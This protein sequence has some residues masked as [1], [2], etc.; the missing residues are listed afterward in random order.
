MW[1]KLAKQ[2]VLYDT[3]HV[4]DQISETEPDSRPEHLAR[5]KELLAVLA[6]VEEVT[7]MAKAQLGK[8]E[9]RLGAAPGVSGSRA[10]GGRSSEIGSRDGR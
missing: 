9:R 6:E 3:Y 2:T 7:R 4:I 10:T 5:L 1:V 8:L